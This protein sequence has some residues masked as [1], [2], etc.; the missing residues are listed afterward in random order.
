MG[1]FDRIKAYLNEEEPEEKEAAGESGE[2][3]EQTGGFAVLNPENATPEP[4]LKQE[5]KA[6]PKNRAKY[7]DAEGEENAMRDDADI[8]ELLD[9]LARGKS[10]VNEV[11]EQVAAKAQAQAEAEAQAQQTI[12]QATAGAQAQARVAAL[13]ETRAATQA[14]ARSA[15]S[16]AQAAYAAQSKKKEQPAPEAQPDSDDELH[17]E[18]APDEE[19][20]AILA[21]T[22]AEEA[23]EE[24]EEQKSF[25]RRKNKK[26][27]KKEPEEEKMTPQQKRRV[28]YEDFYEIDEKADKGKKKKKSLK[29]WLRNLYADTDDGAWDYD[30]RIRRDVEMHQEV[31]SNK[32]AFSEKKTVSDFCEQ[33]VDLT[34]Q[35]EDLK[36]E[37]QLVTAYLVDIQKIEELPIEIAREIQDTAR[38]I[39]MLE[40]NKQTY[41]QSENLLPMEQ[42]NRMQRLEDEV[43][44][45]AVKLNNMEMRD[46]MLKSDMGHLEGEKE[47][48]KYMR[49]EF[50]TEIIRTRGVVSTVLILFLITVGILTSMALVSKIN[51]MLPALAIGLVAVISFVV[52]YVHYVDLKNEIKVTDAKLKRAI[53]LL[54]KV[55]VKYINNTNTMDYIYE[56]YGVNSGKELE[57]NW[58]L[59]TKMVHDAM[60]YSQANTDFR[61]YC[62][63]LVEEL[64]RIGVADPYVWPKQTQAL[65]DHREMVEI[66]H[67][68]N[69][70]RQKLREQLTSCEKMRENARIALHASAERSPEMKAYIKEVL[71][72]YKIQFT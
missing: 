44:E 41:L 56:K 23:V 8:D 67:G 55:K 10:G 18:A 34:Y 50:A 1:L 48:L 6:Q 71:A 12:V 43:Q 20:K 42:F 19:L 29:Q 47:D 45:T 38:K 53:S 32:R 59:Y 27:K 40:K 52:A 22:D 37:Y 24:E 2:A 68:L 66:K 54:N 63:E 13:D 15:K 3:A 58:E 64:R 60:R 16:A 26:K 46:S 28:T 72:S 17:L 14:A 4:A 30:A 39:E 11:A 61:V 57:Y 25:F 5:K 70:R 35:E 62:D 51:I 33:L 36:R 49:E 7:S 65:I 21:E 69:T 31:V 9:S